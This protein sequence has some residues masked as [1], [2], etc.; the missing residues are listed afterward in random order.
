MNNFYSATGDIIKKKC[1]LEPKKVLI[2]SIEY[3]ANGDLVIEKDEREHVTHA[4][5][6]HPQ[7]KDNSDNVKGKYLEE[8]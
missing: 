7:S 8:E 1:D 6:S 3:K 2:E 4:L 5:N